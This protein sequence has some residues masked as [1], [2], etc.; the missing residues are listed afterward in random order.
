[1]RISRKRRGR[2]KKS[3]VGLIASISAILLISI[4]GVVVYKTYPNIGQQI[5]TWTSSLIAKNEGKEQ[6][7]TM[8]QNTAANEQATS[9]EQPDTNGQSS[10]QETAD[11]QI[12]AGQAAEQPQ[13]NEK[14]TAQQPATEQPTVNESATE[15]PAVSASGYI[16]G[17][18]SP[19]EPT[20]INGVLLANKLY[21]LP[22]TYNPGEDP[23]ARAA[24]E[25]MAAAAKQAGFELVAFSGFR[26]YDYQTTLYNNYVARDGQANADR[27]S[28]RPGYSEH[29]TGLAFDIGEKGREDLWLTAEFGETPAGQW[30]ANNAHLYGFILR[31]PKGKEHVTGFMYE[32]W[33]F[34]YLGVEIAT[35]VHAS[36]L[37]LEEY[38]QVQ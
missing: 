7:S 17:Q 19:A 9:T 27:Y 25:Q 4:I 21:P 5:V 18:P 6:A 32:S 3:K 15:Q 14:P 31:Y 24:F 8:E 36:G 23:A 29:Q 16:E 33:H 28:A 30:L 22:K 20:Y 2:Q 35:K 12:N 10:E 1:M 37:T 11:S 26:S 13:Q 34:R 38:L